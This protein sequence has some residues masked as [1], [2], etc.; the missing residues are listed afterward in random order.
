MVIFAQWGFFPKN[1]AVTHNYIRPPNTMLTEK[2]KSRESLQTDRQTQFHRTLPAEAR[3]PTRVFSYQKLNLAW[4]W[5]YKLF[6]D[7][8]KASKNSI[9]KILLL[10]HLLLLSDPQFTSLCQVLHMTSNFALIFL[11]HYPNACV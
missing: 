10:I 2:T 5:S 1:P 3:S 4:E 9:R 6:P 8:Q 7:R 11:T